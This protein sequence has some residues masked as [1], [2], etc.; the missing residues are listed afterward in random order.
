MILSIS[1]S[2]KYPHYSKCSVS[3]GK[4]GIDK[5]NWHIIYPWQA[6]SV[7]GDKGELKQLNKIVL[8]RNLYT[9]QVIIYF[10]LAGSQS[11]KWE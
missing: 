7:H 1:F 2:A 6:D 5:P 9:Q 11:V 8:G 4:G 3:L 10:H